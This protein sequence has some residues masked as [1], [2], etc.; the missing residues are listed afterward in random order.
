MKTKHL[1][2]TGAL[3]LVLA[4]N[5]F[6]LP[7]TTPMKTTVTL[8]AF[9]TISATNIVFGTLSM[10]LSAQSSSGKLQVLCS[11]AAPYTISLAYGGIYGQGKPGDGSYWEFTGGSGSTYYYQR[12]GYDLV[13]NRWVILERRTLTGSNMGYMSLSATTALGCSVS[14]D[15]CYMGTTSYDYGRM[16]GLG[17]GDGVAYSISVPNNPSVTW[18]SGKGTYASAGTGATQDIPLNTT[19]VPAQSS[20]GYPAADMYMDTVTVTINY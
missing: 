14:A 4:S 19:I 13:S 9:C 12:S 18:N 3:A 8:Q 11:R 6:A 7:A 15:R 17:R 2:Y 5:A 1:S 10:P 20:S 16:N